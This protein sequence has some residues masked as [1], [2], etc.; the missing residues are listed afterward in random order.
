VVFWQLKTLLPHI[1]AFNG[2]EKSMT[3]AEIVPGNWD[4]TI[5]DTTKNGKVCK[6]VRNSA[7]MPGSDWDNYPGGS[8]NG[9]GL[10]NGWDYK[11]GTGT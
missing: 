10:P 3:I 4:F 8:R 5:I 6:W 2:I 7:R 9:H 11:G 1:R